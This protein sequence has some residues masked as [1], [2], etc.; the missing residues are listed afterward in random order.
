[1]ASERPLIAVTRDVSTTLERCELTHLARTSIDV[2]R[3][4]VQH[5]A[6]ERCLAEAG[7]RVE[8]LTADDTMP[9]SVFV[10]DICVVFAEIALIT[11]PGAESRR[12]ETPAIAAAL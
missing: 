10:E 5:E 2:S 8:R 6:Y 1:M 7:C 12:L 9:D 3:A 11:R 4:R